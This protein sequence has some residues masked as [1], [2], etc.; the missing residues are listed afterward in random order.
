MKNIK[1]SEFDPKLMQL[2]KRRQVSPERTK[3]YN[4]VFKEIYNLLSLTPSEL[5]KEARKEQQPFLDDDKIHRIL[6]IDERNLNSYHFIYDKYLSDKANAESTKEMKLTPF[7]CFFNE[8][9]IQL[10]RPMNYDTRP[11]RIRLNDIPTG[12]NVKNGLECCDFERKRAIVSLIATSGIRESEVANFTIQ[13]FLDATLIYHN[14]TLED[15]LS[16]DPFNIIPYW[17]F[18]PVKTIREGNLCITFNTGECA[19]YIFKYL[20]ERIVDGYSV[21]SED[22]L[23]RSLKHPYFMK[24]ATVLVMFQML[25][26]RFVLGKDKNGIYGNF[27]AHNLG[28]LF[29]TTCRRNITKV[30]SRRDKY[31]ELDI[32]SVFTGHTPPNMSNSDVYNAVD[33]E[34]SKDNFLRQS[35]ES[36]APYLSISNNAPNTV[37]GSEY[38]TKLMQEDILGLKIAMNDVLKY[39]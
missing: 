35:Y 32:I 2:I 24:P 9:H 34:D 27:R 3:Q 22:P 29:S 38:D 5:L 11:N 10:P 8:F 39:G 1:F 36:L 26:K 14:V 21:N 25:N 4:I 30:I 16:K 28:K 20:E 15:L 13:D 33:S 18:M 6:E 7:R 17:D 31:T 19:F 12:A 23:F 37:Q